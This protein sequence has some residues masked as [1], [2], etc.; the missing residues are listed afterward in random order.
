MAYDAFLKLDGIDGESTDTMHKGEI[1]ILSFSWG[2]N[3]PGAHGTGGGGGAGKVQVQDF[4][5][6]KK[7]DTSSQK[8]LIGLL[9]GQH[10]KKA[11]LSCRKAGGDQLDDFIKLQFS[12]LMMS[13]FVEGGHAG[14]EGEDTPLEQVSFNF[15]KIEFQT[16]SQPK[17][18]TGAA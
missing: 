11:V 8:I 9:R 13:S 2:V 5:F 16:V 1:E 4:S 7:P 14:A 3:N 12:D 18:P 17:S 10:F 15:S 6:T